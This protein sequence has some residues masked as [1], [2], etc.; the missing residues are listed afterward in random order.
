MSFNYFFLSLYCSVSLS[1]TCSLYRSLFVCFLSVFISVPLF[2]SFVHSVVLSGCQ[3]CD[4]FACLRLCFC[5]FAL[6]LSFLPVILARA[7]PSPTLTQNDSTTTITATK[8]DK[9]HPPILIVTLVT[10]ST[11]SS[12]SRRRNS[13][14]S[15]SFGSRN[16]LSPTR[17]RS[18]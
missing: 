4:P 2:R 16:V 11:G 10:G 8:N 15:C 14:S 12:S 18:T 9:R 1:L 13:S 5:L 7:F 17:H 3:S 6:L